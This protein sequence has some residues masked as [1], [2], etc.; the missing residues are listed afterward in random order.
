MV[1]AD[2]SVSACCEEDLKSFVTLLAYISEC[3]K[4]G[5]N[6]TFHVTV[7]GDGSGRYTFFDSS[8]NQVGFGDESKA[9]LDKI[10]YQDN[11]KRVYLGE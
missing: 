10:F 6:H 4:R 5:T 7:D 2:F 8:K 11:P 1:S 9:E 3:G